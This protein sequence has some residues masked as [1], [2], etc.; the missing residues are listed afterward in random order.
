MTKT[1]T[2]LQARTIRVIKA[3]NILK[4]A[5]NDIAKQSEKPI[6]YGGNIGQ[7]VS[8]TENQ[9]RESIQD[10][11]DRR[12]L[13]A[14]ID[15]LEPRERT[16]KQWNELSEFQRT[17]KLESRLD[18]KADINTPLHRP[19]PNELP[20]AN[21]MRNTK[22]GNARLV[23]AIYDEPINKRSSIRYVPDG[24]SSDGKLCGFNE[25]EISQRTGKPIRDVTPPKDL[26]DRFTR[27]K[28]LARSKRCT[29][30]HKEPSAKTIAKMSL[31]VPDK[32]CDAYPCKGEFR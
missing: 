15:T 9:K 18:S 30:C 32:S 1:K 31:G 13:I 2:E 27:V 17:A 8:H 28:R 4:D 12:H 7:R 3:S 29:V 19:K 22:R 5:L 6:K 11:A 26:Q 16:T 14:H 24:R 23:A 10:A 25:I 21:G 20:T